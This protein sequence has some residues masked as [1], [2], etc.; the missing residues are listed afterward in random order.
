[1]PAIEIRLEWLRVARAWTLG[2]TGD[3]AFRPSQRDALRHILVSPYDTGGVQIVSSD[4]GAL[5][6]Q[7]DHHGSVDGTYLIEGLTQADVNHS[8]GRPIFERWFEGDPGGQF[9]VMDGLG[10][11]VIAKL[12]HVK[13]RKVTVGAGYPD[14]ERAIPSFDEMRSMQSGFPGHVSVPYLALIG[15]MWTGHL[16]NCRTVQVLSHGDMSKPTVLLFLWR[17]D[18]RVVIAPHMNDR[19][20]PIDGD[21]FGATPV[22][23]D[24]DDDL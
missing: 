21:L 10:A 2:A 1:M 23:I 17:P 4:G 7:V 12:P 6:V 9:N 20:M 22:V 18:M 24:D 16:N 3:P 5:C 8:I 19:G 14:W 11:E 13:V 15:R